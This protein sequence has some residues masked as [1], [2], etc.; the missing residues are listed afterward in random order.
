MFSRQ[1]WNT[2]AEKDTR[3]RDPHYVWTSTSVVLLLNSL[4][5]VTPQTPFNLDK[6]MNPVTYSYIN[7]GEFSPIIILSLN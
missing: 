7:F 2:S 1:D 4:F 3:E 6:T 5:W